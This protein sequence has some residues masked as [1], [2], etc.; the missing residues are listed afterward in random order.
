MVYTKK[1]PALFLMGVIMVAVG[2]LADFSLMDNVISYLAIEKLMGEMT[3]LPYIF[4]SIAV[5]VG[6]W[7]WFGEHKE[8]PSQH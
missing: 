1:H 2:A 3:T 4:G 8:V 5:V 7:H 6:L